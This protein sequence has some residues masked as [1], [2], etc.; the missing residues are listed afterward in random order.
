MEK[1]IP[2]YCALCISR[3]GCISTVHDGTLIAVEPDP[4][5]PTGKHLCIKG[6]TAPEWVNSS[7]R[8][9]TP[10]KR[11]NPKGAID[12]GW[13][14]ITWDEALD[15]IS[16]QLKRLA[17]TDGQESVAFSVT[18]PSGTGIADSFAWI[19]RL[20]HTY[21]SPNTVFATENCNWHKDFTPAHTFGG[22]IGMPDYEQTGCIILWGFN[23]TTS[24]LAQ[25]SAVRDAKRRG[26]KLIVI[27]CRKAGLA[28]MADQWLRVRPGS[29]GPLAMSLAHVMIE[30]GWYDDQFIR[31]WSNGP[32][33]VR[34]DNGC[35]L[36]EADLET[37]GS[38]QRFLQ[39]DEI[40]NTAVIVGSAGEK[41]LQATNYPALFGEYP[42][43]TLQGE[44]ICSPVFQHY[45]DLCRE[46]AP[47]N[48]V[49]ITGVSA[50]QII[51]TARMLHDH[52]P[53]SYFTWTGTAQQPEASQTSRAISLL[54][55]LTGDFDSPG[56]NVYFEK[57]AITNF[58][59]LELLEEKQKEKALGYIERPV[60]PGTMG[61]I[62]SKD[63]YRAVVERAPYSV[64][65]LVSFGGNPQLT[66]PPTVHTTSALEQ[67]EFYVHA[68]MFMNPTAEYAD[69]FLPVASPWERPGLYPGFHISQQAEAHI[70]LRPPVIPPRGESKS[71]MWIV[72]ELAVR[73]G[74]GK[75]FFAGDMNEALKQLLKP[76]GVDM[77]TLKE[78]PRGIKLPLKTRYQKYR[79][80]G[81][82]TPS[83]RLE[84][85][86]GCLQ[87][88]GYDP[89]PRFS[90]QAS[91]DDKYPL[92]LTSAKWVQYCHSQQRNVP[93]L[94]RRMPD[95]L[96]EL[97]PDA[98]K[99]RDINEGDWVVIS[100]SHGSIQARAKFNGSLDVNVVCA[101]YG[102]WVHDEQS[103]G[104]H[105]NRLID[106]EHFDSISSSNSLRMSYCNIH[107]SS[108]G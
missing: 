12:P 58:F 25:A 26:A 40:Q 105:Y 30:R 99:M 78:N 61:W 34:S 32:F 57:P 102:W 96:L 55:A 66:K 37:G 15:T 67:L 107:K 21:G 5:H 3:C 53:V 8:I 47:D 81:F 95:P 80:Q 17:E 35:L 52:G 97:H 39:W 50:D 93:S 72:F 69:I 101:Q 64:K 38:T 86:S 76:A 49:E 83:G 60:G 63:L 2:G 42:V 51:E 77:K 31:N 29:D 84:L 79:Q 46:Y 23:P 44:V 16:V 24:W 62:S 14:P 45:A 94:R 18:T 10:L 87:S 74:L 65:A 82:A 98:G 100:T 104:Q 91:A 13:Q 20:A 89:L 9:L 108:L 103:I 11:T 70:Q 7:D 22:G 28:S 85:F 54:Y 75:H 48:Q 36:S 68:D 6:R 4:T 41:K 43:N 106:A 27:D 19:N 1:R 90:Q 59:G 33:L 56:G 92:L 73:L 71:D 88:N